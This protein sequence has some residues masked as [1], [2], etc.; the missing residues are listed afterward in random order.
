MHCTNQ[1]F[2]AGCNFDEAYPNPCHSSGMVDGGES[3]R[4]V[5]ESTDKRLN[6]EN[7]LND[8]Q[9]HQLT[10]KEQQQMKLRSIATRSSLLN[11]LVENSL[12]SKGAAKTI[13]PLL[14]NDAEDSSHERI[15]LYLL[16]AIVA[17]TIMVTVVMV[18]VI[19][20]WTK[21]KL[22]GEKQQEQPIGQQ[23]IANGNHYLSNQQHQS[24]RHHS[25]RPSSRLDDTSNRV[26][27][28]KQQP[29][30]PMSVVV[31]KGRRSSSTIDNSVL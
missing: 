22:S 26:M 17:L 15:V 10:F 20:S 27:L 3:G 12:L 4:L 29:L 30:G 11:M 7:Q 13:A 5:D 14:D 28:G 9:R 2:L 21:S 18:M 24:R 6:D 19:F 1:H 23:T 31:T 16:I 8:T 25:S